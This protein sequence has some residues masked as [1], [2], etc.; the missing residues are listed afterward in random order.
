MK[1]LNKILTKVLLTSSLTLISSNVS[2]PSIFDNSFISELRKYQNS[3]IDNPAL[4]GG[5]YGLILK[6]SPFDN[7]S[8]VSFHRSHRSHSSHRSHY[9][10]Y[11][12]YTTSPDVNNNSKK[13]TNTE[14]NSNKK[15]TILGDRILEIGLKGDDVKQLQSQL[16]KAGYPKVKVNGKFD[17]AT[18]KALKDFQKLNNLTPTGKT[19]VMTIY[20]LEKIQ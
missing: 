20:L 9:S 16:R 13:K 3:S 10:H 18:E 17:S 1:K 15:S 2:E 12:S 4:I 14:N 11:S 5:S 6:K 8:F 7:N 19:D